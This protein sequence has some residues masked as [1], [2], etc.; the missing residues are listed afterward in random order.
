MSKD[1]KEFVSLQNAIYKERQRIEARLREINE[2]LNRTSRNGAENISRQET[3]LSRRV[4]QS[5]GHG[6]GRRNALSLKEAVLKVTDK[7]SLTKQEI[8]EAVRQLGYKFATN[9]PLNSLGV[10]LYGKS[11]RFRNE[12]G[13]FRPE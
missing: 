4:K 2:V 9:D 10:I 1:V 12:N 6:R 8:L 13:R 3:G 11:P 7:G 5:K